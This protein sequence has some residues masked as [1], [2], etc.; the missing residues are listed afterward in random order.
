MGGARGQRA[1]AEAWQG[2]SNR[3]VCTGLDDEK[4]SCS[5]CCCCR[6]FRFGDTLYCHQGGHVAHLANSVVS[7][8]ADPH[9]ALGAARAYQLAEVC[10]VGWMKAGILKNHTNSSTAVYTKACLWEQ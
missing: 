1:R 3:S 9:L 4:L 10:S 2:D 7:A 8:R 5:W 6:V